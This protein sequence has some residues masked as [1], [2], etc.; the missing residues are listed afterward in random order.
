[1]T[2]RRRRHTPIAAAL[3][4]A[5]AATVLAACA[6]SAPPPRTTATP[7]ALLPPGAGAACVV[8][9]SYAEAAFNR[10]PDTGDGT[11]CGVVTAVS[12]VQAASPLNR[13]VTVDCGLALKMVEWDRAVVQP[14]AREMFGQEVKTIHHYGGYVCRGR[15]SNRSRLSEHAYGRAIDIGAFELEDGTIISIKS[16]WSGAG[17]R[18]TFL[19]RAAA[20]ACEVFNVVLTPA[21]DRAHED[22]FHLDVGPWKLC[23]A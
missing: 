2:R 7:A 16:H 5:L 10:V 20:G 13:A 19:R 9:L 14:L 15:S 12:L 4:L 3:A 6:G 21:H 8:A 23:R 18:S 22:H 1:M 17:A 11:G